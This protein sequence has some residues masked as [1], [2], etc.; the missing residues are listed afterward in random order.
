LIDVSSL[1]KYKFEVNLEEIG[2]VGKKG[3]AV[4]CGM[5]KNELVECRFRQEMSQQQP[6]GN[7]KNNTPQSS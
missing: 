3:Q 6:N 1:K 4:S 5:M 2:A 7:I